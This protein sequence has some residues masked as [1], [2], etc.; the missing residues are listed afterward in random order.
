MWFAKWFGGRVDK[1]DAEDDEPARFP[2]FDEPAQRA[3]QKP[4]VVP[5]TGSVNKKDFDPYN[6]GSFER[7]NTWERIG[8]R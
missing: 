2:V 8:R 7:R 1:N 3:Q 6:S 5:P 4:A